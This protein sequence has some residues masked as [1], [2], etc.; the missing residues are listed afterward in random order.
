MARTDRLLESAGGS[1]RAAGVETARLEAEVLLAA[2]TGRSRV[3][4]LAFPERAVP[5][6][7][8]RQFEAWLRR[9]VRERVPV[10][11]LTRRQEF[12]SLELYVDER[13]LIPR[14]ETECLV[15]EVLR[16]AGPKPELW[17]DVG[18]GS[19]AVA[20]A[21]ASERPRCRV[22]A[23]DVSKAALEVAALNCKRNPEPGSRV[24][25]AVSHLLSALRPFFGGVQ[26]I[27]ANLPYLSEEESSTLPPEVGRHEPKGALF[28][29]EDA[30]AVIRL[31]LPQAA[32]SLGPGGSLHLEISP[33]LRDTV[34]DLVTSSGSFAA[35]EV[36][37]DALGHPRVVS[38][39]RLP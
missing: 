15:E 24:W 3:D 14:P 17:V 12:W 38:A 18:T 1:L 33:G 13:V 28:A 22:L 2:A 4:L 21:L 32:E 31:L 7:A 19:G 25:L 26:R 37:K 9:R 6:P 11:Y 39:V 20:L 35:A 34:I 23:L 27:A 29:G 8:R 36:R 10:Q 5:A 16:R 30:V